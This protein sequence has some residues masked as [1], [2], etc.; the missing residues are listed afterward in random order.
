MM[1]VQ[2]R[3]PIG[4]GIGTIQHPPYNIHHTVQ[5]CSSG[6]SSKVGNEDRLSHLYLGSG[7]LVVW[8][9]GGLAGWWSH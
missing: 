7:G 5:Y 8:W 1:E 4:S 2:Q 6:G 9:V 3:R